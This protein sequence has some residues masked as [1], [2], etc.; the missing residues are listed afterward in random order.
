MRSARAR[1]DKGT[2]DA[3]A[4]PAGVINVNPSPSRSYSDEPSGSQQCGRR[5]PGSADGA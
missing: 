2:T 4:A 1:S 5:A 3:A